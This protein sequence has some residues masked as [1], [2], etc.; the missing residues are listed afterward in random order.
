MLIQRHFNY[1]IPK[2]MVF[3]E[4]FL[5]NIDSRYFISKI[6]EGINQENNEN[7]K[8]NVKGKMTSWDYFA[9]D[10]KFIEIKND[11]LYK[12]PVKYKIEKL[13]IQNAWGFKV[14]KGE[15]TER[16]NHGFGVFALV[17]YF[18][19]CNTE[20][21][22]HELDI[23]VKPQENKFIFCSG[24]LDHETERLNDDIKYGI[25]CNLY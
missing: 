5:N 9:K 1:T 19:S 6:E 23:T 22:F 15:S 18:T 3:I 2:D 17:I 24:H 8:T 11:L 13:I 20:T 16:H 25:A 4:G 12:V 14:T 10:K 21:Y 7:Y